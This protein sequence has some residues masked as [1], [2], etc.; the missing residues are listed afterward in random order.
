M[1]RTAFIWLSIALLLA[2]STTGCDKSPRSRAPVSA[3]V[4]EEPPQ[5]MY[6]IT[7][8][9][10]GGVET[11]QARRAVCYDHYV[12]FEDLETGKPGWVYGAAKIRQK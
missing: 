8:H 5:T 6:E 11:I 10:V 1:N 3:S 12:Y 9:T 4:P 7:W 2:A